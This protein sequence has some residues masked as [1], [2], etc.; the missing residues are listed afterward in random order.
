MLACIYPR[1]ADVPSMLSSEQSTLILSPAESCC[2]VHRRTWVNAPKQAAAQV[3]LLTRDADA[4]EEASGESI[5]APP[6]SKLV[7]STLLAKD[8]ANGATNCA[9][10]GVSK[11]A[12]GLAGLMLGGGA[13]SGVRAP[14]A[15]VASRT[16]A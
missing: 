2:V 15:A 14:V 9:A 5:A 10:N 8:S 16:A 13:R 6:P 4:P 3:E 11:V 7:E 12:N 1:V